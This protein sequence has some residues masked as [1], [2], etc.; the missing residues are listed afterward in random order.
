MLRLRGELKKDCKDQVR[1][2]ILGRYR[3]V[4]SEKGFRKHPKNQNK[5][6]VGRISLDEYLGVEQHCGLKSWDDLP[7]VREGGKHSKNIK[8]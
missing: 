4:V 8:N 3:W 5:E 7:G 1:S 2:N 6:K